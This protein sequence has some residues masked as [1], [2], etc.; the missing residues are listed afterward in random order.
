MSALT[1][2]YSPQTVS[3]LTTLYIVFNDQALGLGDVL[4]GFGYV[5]THGVEPLH[6]RAAGEKGHHL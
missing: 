1:I 2:R 6:F 5:R 3:T 4:E